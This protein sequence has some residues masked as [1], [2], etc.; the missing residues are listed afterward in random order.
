MVTPGFFPVK[1]EAI[2]EGTAMHARIPVYQVR[3]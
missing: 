1:I 2:P 3:I